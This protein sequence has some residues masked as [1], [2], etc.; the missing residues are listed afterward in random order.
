MSADRIAELLAANNEYQQDARASRAQAKR[1]K[2]ERD[3]ANRN[4]DM[5][6]SQCERQAEKL[7][8]FRAIIRAALPI[9]EQN[10]NELFD[11]HQIDGELRVEDEHDQI[12]AND[13]AEMD[14]WLVSARCELEAEAGG[15]G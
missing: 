7:A 8:T 5:W 11:G 10:R 3:R 9:I 6:Q 2:E 1:Y 15:H 13:I 12:A 4:R 14:L